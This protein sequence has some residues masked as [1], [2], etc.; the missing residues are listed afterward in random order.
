MLIQIYHN[1][2]FAGTPVLLQM[3]L[4]VSGEVHEVHQSERVHHDGRLRQE[5]L[6]VS[7]GSV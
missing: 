4:L 5:L 6:L 3:L 2:N 1:V 7:K